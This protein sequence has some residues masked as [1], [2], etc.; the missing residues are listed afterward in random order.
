LYGCEREGHRLRVF[1]NRLVGEYMNL[2]ERKKQMGGE[3]YIM[4]FIIY[5]VHQILVG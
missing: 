2:S 4:R 1:E 3:Y 5:S